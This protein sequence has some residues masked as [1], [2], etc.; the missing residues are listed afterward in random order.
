MPSGQAKAA[1]GVRADRH[2]S[3]GELCRRLKD[4]ADPC[5][6][7]APARGPCRLS[8]RRRLDRDGDLPA[9]R[10]GG[11]TRLDRAVDEQDREVA[12]LPARESPASG[13]WREEQRP[14]LAGH[15]VGVEVRQ[16]PDTLGGG[17]GAAS[18]RSCQAD[19]PSTSTGSSSSSSDVKRPA[20]QVG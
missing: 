18:R 5:H 13:R 14:G 6:L 2:R 9:R 1:S 7:L 12:G 20:A 11:A 17:P 10:V 15:D 3:H 8:G 4:L 16:Q 19:V